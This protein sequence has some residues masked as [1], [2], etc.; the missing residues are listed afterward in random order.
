MSPERRAAALATNIG[1][2]EQD[3]EVERK[4]ISGLENLLKVPINCHRLCILTHRSTSLLI[5]F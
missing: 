3:I 1:E 5:N 2:L 4:A